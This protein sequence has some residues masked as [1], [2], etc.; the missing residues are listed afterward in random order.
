MND[1]TKQTTQ[2]NQERARTAVVQPQRGEQQ[3]DH[4]IT[5]PVP[6]PTKKKEK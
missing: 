5:T 3:R 4:S 6:P 1:S 2:T